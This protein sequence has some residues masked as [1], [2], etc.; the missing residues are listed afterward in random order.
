MVLSYRKLFHGL[1]TKRADILPN[2]PDSAK[3]VYNYCLWSFKMNK[4]SSTIL[5]LSEPRGTN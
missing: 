1:E 5:S 3:A 2:A 4:I